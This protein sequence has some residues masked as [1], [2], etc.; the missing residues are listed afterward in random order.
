MS[1]FWTVTP[2][3]TRNRTLLVRNVPAGGAVELRCHGRGCPSK[4]PRNVPVRN[5]RADVHRIFRNHHLR[6][7]TWFDIRIT[8]PGMIGKVLRMKV[9]RSDIPSQRRLCLAPG[10]TSASRC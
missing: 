1:H 4:R 10:A 3:W 7:G 8:A 9:R 6:P 2:R 5:G